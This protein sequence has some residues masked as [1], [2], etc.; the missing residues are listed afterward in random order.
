MA[1]VR[2]YKK[3]NKNHKSLSNKDIIIGMDYYEFIEIK[4]INKELNEI[5]LF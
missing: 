3:K 5:I 4:F 2:T 1:K